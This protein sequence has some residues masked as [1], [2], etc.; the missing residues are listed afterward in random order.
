M[1]LDVVECRH[2][3]DLLIGRLNNNHRYTKEKNVDFDIDLVSSQQLWLQ[4][5]V[6]EIRFILQ[7]QGTV[8]HRVSTSQFLCCL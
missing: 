8:C 7:L 6:Q 3:D 4:A 5:T 1:K 2:E